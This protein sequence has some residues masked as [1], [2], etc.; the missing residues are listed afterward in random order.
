MLQ[1]VEQPLRYDLKA[2]KDLGVF[3]DQKAEYRRRMMF[4]HVRVKGIVLDLDESTTVAAVP[5]PLMLFLNNVCRPGTYVADDFLT[6]Y[7]LNRIDL[8]NYGA[9]IN[10]DKWQ[11]KMIAGIFLY[12]RSLIMDILMKN[13][14]Q[15]ALGDGANAEGGQ[16]LPE[17]F[18]FVATILY[19]LFMKVV[20]AEM[21]EY[22]REQDEKGNDIFSAI[23]FEYKVVEEFFQPT[24]LDLSKKS[25]KKQYDEQLALVEQLKKMLSRWLDKI[26]LL[27]KAQREGKLTTA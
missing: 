22:Q 2:I 12:V 1:D 15:K 25:E 16:N 26:Y 10:L 13:A 5:E 23:L 11:Q 7:Q 18:K 24:Y 20:N 19:Y 27:M 17:N 14:E 4:T 3:V 8:D 21:M 9:I 6:P